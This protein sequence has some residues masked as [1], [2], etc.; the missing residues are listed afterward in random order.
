MQEVRRV[1][2]NLLLVIGVLLISWA[3]IAFARQR[4]AQAARP[5]VASDS[6]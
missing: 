1:W 2:C 5:P 4:A 6:D 3:L